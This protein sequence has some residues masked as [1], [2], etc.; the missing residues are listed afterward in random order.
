MT[1]KVLTRDDYEEIRRAFCAIFTVEPWNDDW[2]DEEQLREY[3]L[4]MTASRNSLT[5]GLFDSSGAMIGFGLGREIHW[6]EGTE[7]FLDEFGVLPEHC[8]RGIGTRFLRLMEKRLLERGLRALVLQ[9]DRRF[10]AYGFYL[11][12]GFAE[13]KTRAFMMKF[14]V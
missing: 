7:Y 9:T 1:L 8:G 3:L 10:A 2:S 14:L 11:K 6:Y 13:H 5:F 4:D 12:N